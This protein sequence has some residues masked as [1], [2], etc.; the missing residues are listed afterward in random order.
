MGI[1]LVA[2]AIVGPHVKIMCWPLADDDDDAGG[3][4]AEQFTVFFQQQLSTLLQ[5]AEKTRIK[6][7]TV[8]WAD[9]ACQ[10][11][12][13][14]IKATMKSGPTAVIQ[15]FI[16]FDCQHHSRLKAAALSEDQQVVDERAELLHNESRDKEVL[17][18]LIALKASS[19]KLN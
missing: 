1:V 8:A 16:S 13:N 10:E 12:T 5:E 15:D 2:F 4:V 6:A 14:S 11:L 7:A 18:M 3:C 9:V 19:R 17:E